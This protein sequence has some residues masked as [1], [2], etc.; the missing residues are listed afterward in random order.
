MLF[1]TY[2]KLMLG[3]SDILV[4]TVIA[5]NRINSISLL[6]FHDRILRFGKKNAFKSEKVFEQL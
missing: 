2:T 6:F 1:Q 4:I 5:W 3:L